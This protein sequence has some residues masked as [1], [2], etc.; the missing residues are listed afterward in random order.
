M[1][2]AGLCAMVVGKVLALAGDGGEETNTNEGVVVTWESCALH[3]E[4][5]L[6]QKLNMT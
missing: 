1:W 3:K 4:L 5:K 2:D 6:R